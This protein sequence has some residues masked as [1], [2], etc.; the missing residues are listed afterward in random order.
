MRRLLPARD[1]LGQPPCS[2][3]AGNAREDCEFT[4]RKKQTKMKPGELTGSPQPRL[5]R[6]RRQERSDDLR[7]AAV[8]REHQR[9]SASAK[10]AR[11]FLPPSPGP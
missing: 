4:K 7:V 9:G 3:V 8:C 6:P 10:G 5:L 1:A 2:A 11:A